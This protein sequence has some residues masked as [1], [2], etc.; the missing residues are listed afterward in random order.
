MPQSMG[1]PQAM[2]MEAVQAMG[3]PQPQ[4]QAPQGPP[5]PPQQQQ[6]EDNNVVVAGMM[7]GEARPS[8]ALERAG[9]GGDTHD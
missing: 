8:R 9:T 2:P 4:M 6:H 5:P 7:T 3:V 1:V